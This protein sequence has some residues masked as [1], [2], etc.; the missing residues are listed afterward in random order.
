MNSQI[1]IKHATFQNSYSLMAVKNQSSILVCNKYK[2]GKRWEFN[3]S[4]QGK[5]EFF[6]S[7]EAAKARFDEILATLK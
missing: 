5:A 4:H 6:P 1:K 2:L 3:V 7:W